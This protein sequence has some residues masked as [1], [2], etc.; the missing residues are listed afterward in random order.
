LF[1][2]IEHGGRLHHHFGERHRG[3]LDR[4]AAGLQH[5]ALHLLGALA[6][7]RVARI[8][9]APRVDD[10]D[11]RPAGPVGRVVADLAQPR[12]MAERAQVAD[13]EPAM[14]AQVFGAFAVCHGVPY[15]TL[16]PANLT[17]FS[18]L[19]VSA[20]T[21]FPNS[22]GVATIGTP[23]SSASRCLIAGS[24]RI[25]LIALFSIA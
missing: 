17:T 8:D 12:A 21:T 5:A 1:R 11:H 14:A 16:A 25:S 4:E 6:Q 20:W 15:S 18:H 7:V 9:V 22:S 19:S 2:S 13:P 3:Q 23:P 10:A 24:A